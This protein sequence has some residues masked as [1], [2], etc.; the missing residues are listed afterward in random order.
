MAKQSAVGDNFYLAQYDLSGDVGSLQSLNISRALLDVTPISKAAMERI[1][2]RADGEIGFSAFHNASTGQSHAVLKSLPTADVIATF[3]HGATV[4]NDA[5]SVNGKQVD[6]TTELGADGSLVHTSVVKGNGSPV[7]WGAMLTAG[8]VTTS[9]AGTAASHVDGTA[10]STSGGAAYLHVFGVSSGTATVAVYDSADNSSFT[11]VTG[12]TFT[13]ASAATSERKA[14]A[15]GA[16][17][18]RY[19]AVVLSGTFT[20]LDY[21]VNFVRY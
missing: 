5:A 21:F 9:S 16:T 20:G 10:A 19:V 8:R 6:Y 1:L 2:G 3:A 4:G 13:A 17:V 7:E 11:V 18:R 12:L 14:T 15:A